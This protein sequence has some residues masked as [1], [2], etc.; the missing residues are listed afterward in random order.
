VKIKIERPN[1][2]AAAQI[3]ERY[4][5]TELPIDEALV[6][7]LGGGDREKAVR[8]MIEVTVAQMYRID[9]TNRFL[10][11]PTK[12]VTRRSSTSRISLRAR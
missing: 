3:F 10:E 8:A 11:S 6:R 9:D 1:A 2:D 5:H 4:L 12:V 7:E